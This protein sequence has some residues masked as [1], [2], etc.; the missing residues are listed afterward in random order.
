MSRKQ[1]LT[2]APPVTLLLAIAF[3]LVAIAFFAAQAREVG[4]LAPHQHGG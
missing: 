1:A 4:G 3:L 2:G